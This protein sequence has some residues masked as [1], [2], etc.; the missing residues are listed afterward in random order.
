MNNIVI[1]RYL[2]NDSIMHKLDP[3]TKLISMFILMITIFIPSG[4]IGY[5]F[6]GSALVIATILSKLNLSYIWKAI[7]PMIF[8][9]FFLFIINALMLREGDLLINIFGFKIYE[10]AASQTL[11]IVVRIVLMILCATI[12]TATTKPLELTVG[13]EDIFKP[14]KIIKFPYAEMA[15]MLSIALRFIPLLVEETQR[16]IKAQASRGVDISEGSIKEKIS[17]VIALI[18]PL[19]ISSFQKASDLADAME[20][21][22]YMPGEPRTRY[23]QLKMTMTDYSVLSIVMLLLLA[24]IYLAFI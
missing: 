24:N 10:Q 8:M 1:G 3:R 17:S 2:P 12:L 6:V 5:I 15:M 14:L 23:H 7:K 16:I 13:L 11:Y 22:G 19:F 9:L 20:A 18:V 21:R 4:V